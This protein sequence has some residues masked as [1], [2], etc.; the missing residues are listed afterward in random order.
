VIQNFNA[1]FELTTGLAGCRSVSK[2]GAGALVPG[3][4]LA[5]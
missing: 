4:A 1:D 3:T 5:G 2:I